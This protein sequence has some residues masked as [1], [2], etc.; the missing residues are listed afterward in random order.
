MCGSL[1]GSRARR[2]LAHPPFHS[3]APQRQ[4][5][6]QVNGEDTSPAPAARVF[7]LGLSPWEAALEKMVNTPRRKSA[8]VGGEVKRRL[9]SPSQTL[10]VASGQP[11]SPRVPTWPRRQVGAPAPHAAP[12]K[13]REALPAPAAGTGWQELPFSP[14]SPLH[15]EM[16]RIMTG[17]L[18]VGKYTGVLRGKALENQKYCICIYNG[19]VCCSLPYSPSP[20]PPCFCCHKLGNRQAVC[21]C[22]SAGNLVKAG[23]SRG[24]QISSCFLFCLHGAPSP[25]KASS[26]ELHAQCQTLCT[27][28]RDSL[29][30]A[31]AGTKPAEEDPLVAPGQRTR[32]CIASLPMAS[33]PGLPNS[34]CPSRRALAGFHHSHNCGL[35]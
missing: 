4:Q 15:P 14:P 9:C 6:R 12:G 2:G 32:S 13:T 22:S 8:R 28:Y 31:P 34:S 11:V 7:L 26:G 23:C 29:W 17:S 30:L 1:K 16:C 5:L 21:L 25:G 20:S 33:V 35:L 19:H 24:M 18:A 10:C 3:Q 27:S